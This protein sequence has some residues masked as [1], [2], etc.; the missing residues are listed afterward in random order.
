M[1]VDKKV[2]LQ[3]IIG[4]HH[5]PLLRSGIHMLDLFNWMV[6]KEPLVVQAFGEEFDNHVTKMA[7][8]FNDYNINGVIGYLGGAQAILVSGQQKPFVLFELDLIYE[9][10][11]TRVTENGEKT[12]MWSSQPS[13]RYSGLQELARTYTVYPHQIVTQLTSLEIAIHEV[14][15][16]GKTWKNSCSGEDGLAALKVALALHYSATHGHKITVIDDVPESYKVK[17]Y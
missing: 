7:G 8:G 4:I 1:I 12:E 16:S 9:N 10:M 3:T 17:S 5:G 15:G 11:R 6:G 13:L 14:C 2:N